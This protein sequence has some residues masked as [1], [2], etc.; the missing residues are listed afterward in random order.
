MQNA[1]EQQTAQLKQALLA[2]K[3]MRRKL[4]AEKQAKTEPIAIVGM[5]CRFPGANNPDEF[6]QLLAHGIDAATS[7]PQDRWDVEAYHDSN[8][9]TE[10][11]IYVRQGYFLSDIDQFD[12]QF[13]GI[14]P[15]E[16]I[17]LDPQQRLLLEI[18]WEALEN[19]CQPPD[20]LRNS[21]T[22]VFMGVM[23]N[24]YSRRLT[25]Q[26][27]PEYLNAYYGTGNGLSFL[28]G[29]LSYFLGLQGPAMVLDTACSSSLV[30]VHLACQSLRLQ[31]CRL[32]LAGGVNL[33][34]FPEASIALSRMQALAAD[35]HCKTFDAQAD[36]YARG[37]GCGVV[38]L[39]RL[40]DAQAD[41]DRILAVIRGSAV[42]HDG[43]SSGL[44]VPSGPAQKVLLQQALNHAGVK[45]HQVSY[46]EAHGT[47]TSLGDPIEVQALATVYGQQ[48]PASQPL[49]IGSVKT[50]IGHLESAAGI[51]GLIKVVLGLQHQTI[52]AHLHLQALNPHIASQN[53]H[54]QIP[55]Q[56]IPWDVEESRIA[57]VSS[58]G[59]SGINAH[60]ILAEAPIITSK[61]IKLERT[62]HLFNLSAKTPTALRQLLQSYAQYCQESAHISL[63]DICHTVNSGRNHFHHRLSL[64]ADSVAHLQTQLNAF[65][66]GNLEPIYTADC[67]KMPTPRIV[68]LFTGQGSQY[69]QMGWE[70]YQTQPLFR[71]IIDECDRLLHP[72]LE[73]SLLDVL[74]PQG[75]NASPIHQTAYTQPA[76]FSL[77]YALAQLWLSWGIQPDA[78]MGHSV[79]EYVA[80]C[81]AGVFS[82]EDGLKLIAHR[83]RL[84][85]A[86]PQNGAMAAIFA[87]TER[88]KSLIAPYSIQVAIATI[89]GS[90]NTVIS[91]ERQAVTQILQTLDQQGIGYQSL[92]VSH[93]FHSPLMAPM[94]AEFRQ[95]AQSVTYHPPQINLVSNL[96]GKFISFA[97]IGQPD[98]WCRHI[99]E[100]VQFAAGIETLHQQGYQIF[101]EVGPKPT[102]IGMGRR[103]LP[104]DAA[105][106][107]SSLNVG[108]SDWQYLLTSLSQLYLRGAE[109]NWQNVETG[110]GQNIS[111]PTYPFQRQRFWPQESQLTWHSH[112]C[113]RLASPMQHPLLGQ[114]F[115]S[116]LASD[117]HFQTQL[118]LEAFP[119]LA[120]HQVYNTVVVPAAFYLSMFL[121]A[122]LEMFNAQQQVMLADIS[123]LQALML[124]ENTEITI[125]LVLTPEKS[126]AFTCQ[127]F[128]LT[129]PHSQK[130]AT[131]WVLHAQAQ[132]SSVENVTQK[133][134]DPTA[135]KTRCCNYTPNSDAIYQAAQQ[136]GIDLGST[137]KWLGSLWRGDHEALSQMKSPAGIRHPD[138]YALH[139][140]LIDSCFQLLSA[141]L[142]DDTHNSTAYVPMGIESLQVLTYPNFSTQLQ[143]YAQLRVTQS[144]VLVGDI[145]VVD[146]VNQTVIAIQGLQIKAVNQQALSPHQPAD[147]HRWL[148]K[149][150]WQPQPLTTAIKTTSPSPWLIFADSHGFADS[151]AHYWQQQGQACTLVYPGR[152]YQVKEG[153]YYWIN[154]DHAADFNTLLAQPWGGIVYLW[155]LEKSL[156]IDELAQVQALNCGAVLH[157]IQNLV[158]Q[159]F[160]KMPKLYMITR[161]AQA[162]EP[163]QP[164]AIEQA[165]LWGLGRV[166]ALEHPEVWGGLVDLDPATSSAELSLLGSELLQGDNNHLVAF[167][168][169]Q[170]Y[171]ARLQRQPVLT[172][173]YS[174][175]IHPDCTYLIVGGL[176]AL[177]LQVAHW[178]VERGARYLVL[179]SRRGDATQVKDSL[180]NWQEKGVQVIV[181]AADVAQPESVTQVLTEIDQHLPPLRGIFHTGGV[182]DDGV[183][184]K[185]DW[186]QFAQ[187]MAP[188]V[189][190]AWNLHTQTA[191]LPLDFFV[192]FSSMASLMGSIGQG[193]YAAA[194]AFLDALA[195]HRQSQGLPGL[196]INWGPWAEAGMAVN[197]SEQVQQGWNTKGIGQISPA[198]GLASLEYLMGSEAAQM[199][200]LPIE[201][202][203]FLQQ[204]SSGEQPAFLSDL[205]EVH[206]LPTTS[207]DILQQLAE[208]TVSQRQEI[209][210]NHVRQ[211]VAQ[212]MGLSSPHLLELGQ[213]LFAMGMDSLMAVDL[214]NRLQNS[215][216]QLLPS[217]LVFEYA[218]VEA[219]AKY[220]A[221]NILGWQETTAS[222]SI[223]DDAA[224]EVLSELEQLA[225]SEAEILLANKLA[226]LEARMSIYE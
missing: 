208:A 137:F 90:T 114:R 65:T 73:H 115:S 18:S 171:V 85:Q 140:G 183:L 94:L 146:E 22:G 122:A 134:I 156:N 15:R 4:E 21:Q 105:L 61:S 142:S 32:A 101:L 211:E 66:A 191:Q 14:T 120:D 110:Y 170:R 98:Y 28:A 222:V 53:H 112:T 138:I 188:K 78:V 221:T 69:L 179:T 24:D 62:L 182:L 129:S 168:D 155:G 88:V 167:R 36:G 52:P 91:G 79:G 81:I 131:S 194:N 11:K 204:F 13:F 210:I 205:V 220:L 144:T 86:L 175:V 219:L 174:L 42:N 133:P 216:A 82:L 46:V 197:L 195:H 50:N 172:T 93:A 224:A 102:L 20:Q 47:G 218:S 162:V 106:W 45:Q 51:A 202:S 139:P 67:S 113:T 147:W 104:A 44:T 152:E 64:L 111:L 207:A 200:V 7:I 16:A 58:F 148:H 63:A 87:D 190:G 1:S 215:F 6:W 17:I 119:D 189:L 118:S 141:T 59:L 55:T 203:K 213:G 160:P 217:T 177:G 198:S 43:P 9:D 158:K 143:S 117:I 206:Q 26:G 176:G 127:L 80:A 225:E 135:I 3:E 19:A 184:L 92:Q 57:G 54:I 145:Q 76:L 10:G 201:W 121:A 75:V 49:Q 37:E 41:G 83:A 95:V 193:N 40:S 169:N 161:G 165:T 192:L 128:S 77:E 185:R 39:K 157:L 149:I 72:H 150:T 107:L 12:A 196:S 60:L 181:L 70:L 103:C 178:L 116:P 99:R 123:F 84:M 35:G 27:N 29:R 109:I 33:I 5:G 166:I 151:L 209:L 31:E 8:P 25:A 164:L 214:K 173:P 89:N 187:V 154:P 38:V 212:V 199:G 226:A 223:T 2:L 23:H 56:S 34:L 126:G 68:F 124:P 71:Q 186:S 159:K 163:S 180:K 48:R 30:A 153:K 74:Y 125:Q 97:E 130:T 96:T 100:A 108:G 136:R 132:L